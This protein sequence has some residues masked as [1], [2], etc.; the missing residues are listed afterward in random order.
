[1]RRTILRRHST[2]GA[3]RS[4]GAGHRRI[5]HHHKPTAPAG[6]LT[7]RGVEQCYCGAYRVHGGPWV[8][9]RR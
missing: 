3:K 2:S 1:M 4:P 6:I 9:T 7:T 5:W 8:T